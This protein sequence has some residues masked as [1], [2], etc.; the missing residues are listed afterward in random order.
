HG[1]PQAQ[2]ALAAKIEERFGLQ[3]QIP[4]YLEEMTLRGRDVLA[5]VLHHTEA[6]P[7]VNWDFLASEVER[8]WAMFRGRLVDIEHK[9]W[10]DQKELEDSLAKME[11]Y[12]TR[13][14]ARL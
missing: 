14:L 12:L 10:V 9:P 11:F 6:Y 2:S 4:E 3:A 8:K 13:L 5:T 1:E 7:K